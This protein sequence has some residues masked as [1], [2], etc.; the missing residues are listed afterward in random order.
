MSSLLPRQ[1]TF[2]SL[3]E[4]N[5]EVIFFFKY[6]NLLY[7]PLSLQT[8]TAENVFVTNNVINY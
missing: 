6:L 7:R 3:N 4:I 1:E 2:F 8:Y 5:I